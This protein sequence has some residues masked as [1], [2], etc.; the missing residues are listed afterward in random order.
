V[1]NDVLC[2]FFLE[3]LP[4]VKHLLNTLKKNRT[5]WEELLEQEKKAEFLAMEGSRTVPSSI[6]KESLTKNS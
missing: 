6:D 2:F 5:H 3:L 4:E 1:V